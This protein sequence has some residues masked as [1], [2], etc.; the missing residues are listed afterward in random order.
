MNNENDY[1]PIKGIERLKDYVVEKVFL[2]TKWEDSEI[3]IG[4][5]TVINFS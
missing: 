5:R 1:K 2:K 3:P 4:F